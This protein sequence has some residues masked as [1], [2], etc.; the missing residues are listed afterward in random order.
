MTAALSRGADVAFVTAGRLPAWGAY[1]LLDRGI[2]GCRGWDRLRPDKVGGPVRAL[3]EH[4]TTPRTGDK[5][6]HRVKPTLG[7]TVAGWAVHLTGI[8]GYPRQALR[9]QL[10]DGAGR[11]SSLTHHRPIQIP[12]TGRIRIDRSSQ[13]RKCRSAITGGAH[14]GKA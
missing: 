6:T 9:T 13:G 14:A 7:P 12:R 1:R 4:S 2:A 3:V 8:E 5:S 10:P 11:T